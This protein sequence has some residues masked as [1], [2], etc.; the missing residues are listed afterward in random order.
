MYM[1]LMGI[2]L[3]VE[4]YGT[5][6]PQVLLLHGWGCTLKH[7]QPIIDALKDHYHLTAIDFPA[8]GDSSAPLTAWSVHDFSELV[9]SL[10]QELKLE[11]VHIIAHSFGARVAICLAAERP[12]LV[13]RM[14]LTG[15]AG[16]RPTPTKAQVQR[17]AAYQRGKTAAQLLSKLPGMKKS[18]DALR[19]KLIRKYGSADYAALSPEMRATFS[20]IVSEDLSCFLPSIHAETLLIFG[21]LDTET[22][23]W[24]GQRMEKEIP[25]A[26]LI[27]FEGRGH[28]AYLE[29]WP[30]FCT[31]VQEFLK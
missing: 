28:F 7:F 21:S 6:G 14:V 17:S 26:A 11:P 19:E 9:A 25:D 4:Q 2:Q 27:V 12:E 23:L 5:S 29:E 10:I 20:K 8:H 30:R 1:E 13:K 3:H 18:A 16:I 22:P 31:I 15:A 24:M